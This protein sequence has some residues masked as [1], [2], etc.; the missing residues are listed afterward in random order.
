VQGDPDVAILV[1]FFRQAALQ[2]ESDTS[3]KF[4]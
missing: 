1:T 2:D 3:A 4:D